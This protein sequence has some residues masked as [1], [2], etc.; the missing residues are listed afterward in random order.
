MPEPHRSESTP[1]ESVLAVISNLTLVG[2]FMGIK[3]KR[4]TLVVTD[5]RL[6]FAELTKAKAREL[7]DEAR[8][9]T[10]AEGGSVFEQ[11]GA[12]MRVAQDHAQLYWSI[13]PEAALA[14][15]PGNVAVDRSDI[16][17]V[18]FKYGASET[19]SDLVILK[20][21]S[22]TYK[23]QAAGSLREIEDTL[24]AAGIT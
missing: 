17:K 7:S 13:P 24:A 3:Q 9:R 6:I 21:G 2:G 8:R 19:A 20:T 22:D 10:K 11:L 4:Y 14:E 23:L 16:R 15:T 1:N 18:K 12:Q 5:E